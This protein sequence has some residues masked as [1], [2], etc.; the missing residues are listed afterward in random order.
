MPSSNIMDEQQTTCIVCGSAANQRCSRCHVTSYCNREHQKSHW[1][2][3]K[4]DCRPYV[5]Q[6]NLILG[7]YL[8]ASRDLA[9]GELLLKDVPI[10]LGLRQITM[11]V[12]VSCSAS[13]NGSHC[14]SE[15]GWPL[16]SPECQRVILHKPE[17]QA[18]KCRGSKVVISKFFQINEMYECITP[19]RC[20]WLKQNEPKKWDQLMTMES[21][22]DAR[23][24]SKATELDKTNVIDFVRGYLKYQ[25][26]V[27]E[28]VYK[29]CGILEVN[30][31]E[32]PAPN[33][34]G[35]YANACRLEHSCVPNTSRSFD[36]QMNVVIRAAV[37][38]KK[39]DHITISYTDQ[40][41]GTSS[42]QLHLNTT[43]YFTCECDRCLD[44]TE[45]GTHYSSIVCQNCSA[46]ITP[47]KIRT[48]NWFCTSCN[49]TVPAEYVT[50]LLKTW[51]EILANLRGN[52]ADSEDFLKSTET[53]FSEN[54]H[55]RT[56]VKLALVQ[57][58][59]KQNENQLAGLTD[60]QLKTK[61][62]LGKEVLEVADCFSPGCTRLR[63]LLQFEIG[64]TL[65]EQHRRQPKTIRTSKAAAPML[66]ESEICLT[67]AHQVLSVEFS[68]Q[69][70]HQVAQQAAEVKL[71]VAKAITKCKGKKK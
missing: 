26:F 71:L 57:L 5:V 34:V 48:D 54:H 67:E 30:G 7:K 40:M 24:K 11:P 32:I 25:D 52:I 64:M 62:H 38:I 66:K 33:F 15:C 36:E 2:Q 27:D 42:R 37:P 61:L 50:K 31:F 17:C 13:V 41:W 16:C 58:I 46:L 56:D 47:P 8:V 70:E 28:D 12:C 20:L 35:L 69:D 6:E 45:L 22:L 23:Q 55:Y 4:T 18:S 29:V 21:H 3:H 51:G 43:K 19:L 10:V 63:G 14:C 49:K 65:W 53:D 9:A 68:M 44:P 59:G 60:D 1:K 39:G